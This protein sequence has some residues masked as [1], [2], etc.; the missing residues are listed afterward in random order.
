MTRTSAG[1][2][3]CHSWAY[4]SFFGGCARYV[5]HNR[6]SHC[7]AEGVYEDLN[8]ALVRRT[9]GGHFAFEDDSCQ[10]VQQ[11]PELWVSSDGGK[12]P[13]LEGTADDRAGHSV[14]GA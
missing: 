8:W 4:C 14:V 10:C 9:E 7:Q 6:E 1:A 3:D 5:F 11:N 2:E 12:S 13:S